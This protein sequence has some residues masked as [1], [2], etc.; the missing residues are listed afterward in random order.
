A[1]LL[2]LWAATQWAAAMLTYQSALGPALSEVAGVKIYAPWQ[3]FS[4]WLAFEA[5]APHVF[6]RAGLPAALG[7][8][9]GAAIGP[10]G[11]AW[12]TGPRGSRHDLWLGPLGGCH[13]PQTCQALREQ[14][15]RPR[16]LPRSLPT[17]RWARARAPRGANP[18][19]QGRWPGAA[20]AVELDPVGH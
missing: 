15:C 5:E 14:R 1:C 2:C 11:A 19:R 16:P 17:P 18:I 10:G 3:L 20:H 8:I 13:R 4:W 9:A 7:G 6:A 12:R